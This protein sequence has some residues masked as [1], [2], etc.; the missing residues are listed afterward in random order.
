[1]FGFLIGAPCR[2]IEGITYYQARD[3]P[4]SCNV[5]IVKFITRIIGPKDK[6]PTQNDSDQ[7]N[8]I[9]CQNSDSDFSNVNSIL[10][11]IVLVTVTIELLGHS[12]K[13]CYVHTFCMC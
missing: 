11:P 9:S 7:Q 3:K 6:I 1:M 13:A 12:S 5:G 2:M 10:L 4:F 8:G